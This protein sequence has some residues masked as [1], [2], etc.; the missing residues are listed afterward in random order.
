MGAILLRA[1]NF[2][3]GLIQG[4]EKATGYVEEASRSTS[5]HG[6]L[7]AAIYHE[8]F[9]NDLDSKRLSP[10]IADLRQEA[11]T[12]KFLDRLCYPGMKNRE[13][14]IAEAHEETFKWIFES[15]SSCHGS[16]SS[17]GDWLGSNSNLYW[18]TGK[19]GSG[20]STLMKY[21]CQ[22]RVNSDTSRNG[23]GEG[24]YSSR[25]LHYLQKWA[26]HSKLIMGCYYFWNSGLPVQMSQ[27]GLLLSL[28]H[29]ILTQT[30]ELI[31]S[32]APSRWEALCLFNEDPR[33]WTD[34]ELYKMLLT[35]AKNITSAMK[36]CFFVDGLDEFDGKAFELINLFKILIGAYGVKICVSSRPWT[37]FEESFKQRPSL[38]LQDL[39]SSDIRSYVS[40][41]LNQDTSFQQLQMRESDYANQLIDNVVS[42][43]SGVF[44]WV[45]LVTN[46][47]LAGMAFG[48]RVSDLQRRLDLLPPDLEK[49][50]DNILGSLDPFYMEHAAQLF[51]LVEQSKDPPPL[52]L[53][54]FADE[55]KVDFAIGLDTKPLARDEEVLRTET[56]R[57]RLNSRCKGFLEIG[58]LSSERDNTTEATTQYLHR[59]VREY[60]QSKETRAT[61]GAALNPAFDPHLRLCMGSLAHLKTLDD[62]Y[63]LWFDGQFWC[64]VRRC[65]YH[66]TRVRPENRK[67]VV[68]ILDELDETAGKLAIRASMNMAQSPTFGSRSHQRLSSL[69]ADGQWIHSFSLVLE[70]P[71]FCTTFLSLIVRYG[72]LSYLESKVTQGCLVPHIS[73]GMWP[74]LLDAVSIDPHD[75]LGS[76][77]T[78]PDPRVVAFLL[79]N[80]ADPNYPLY[81]DES[82]SEWTVWSHLL[83][84]LSRE[85]D[86]T[87]LEQPW[88]QIVEMMI[89]HGATIRKDMFY[90][91]NACGWVLENET[92]SVRIQIVRGR[93]I[94]R[95]L[96]EM[97]RQK[98]GNP[99]IRFWL[100]SKHS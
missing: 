77:D 8:D 58:G 60:V 22:E 63:D 47:L 66:A 89:Q 16:Y 98:H 54:S 73:G 55:E 92:E 48:D 41:K 88:L 24:Q 97:R 29:Q 80:G 95:R 32:V 49:L 20:K 69:L 70:Q 6:E 43:A 65:L 35:A 14:G 39:T 99:P 78:V 4:A 56:M 21:L 45:S 23:N 1:L 72:D 44:L 68:A 81:V 83:K 42:K 25:C 64:R 53:L 19:A 2:R 28:L 40:T 61:F 3:I 34:E 31:P 30:P 67:R 33:P 9:Y 50:Y 36:L 100:R 79:A 90:K 87:R 13:E 84:Q 52:L 57:R 85:A 5:I 76:A 15:Q 96:L 37:V 12:R 93:A 59:T 82:R 46:S 75:T 18:M 91:S 10:L 74:L 27:Q 7:M 71:N 62:G 94:Y 17:F 26:G 38:M 11:L 86:I 51:E